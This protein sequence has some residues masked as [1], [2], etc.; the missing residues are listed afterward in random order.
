MSCP[1]VSLR[2]VL[3][4][5]STLHGGGGGGVEYNRRA[6]HTVV[7]RLLLFFIF[8]LGR[9]R[10]PRLFQ[11]VVYCIVLTHNIYTYT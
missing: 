6:H 9:P 8:S 4:L 11:F 5:G 2:L 7:Y 10:F 3:P 1:L